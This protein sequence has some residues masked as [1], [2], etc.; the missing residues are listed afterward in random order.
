M[1]KIFIA[2]LCLIA[3]KFAEAQNDKL[4]IGIMPFNYTNGAASYQDANS[5]QEAVTEGFVKTKRFNIVDRSKMDALKKEKE[6]QKTE[7]FIDGSVVKQGANIG[8]NFLI[9]GNVLE[10]KAEAIVGTKGETLGYKAKLI[11][12]LKVID[13]STGQVVSSETIEPKANTGLFGG[14]TAPSTPEGAIS[15]AIKEISGKI[16]EF[17]AKNFPVTFAIAEIQ[18]KDKN[19]GASKV[20][21]SGGAAFG[22]KKGQKL[23]VV[24]ISEMTVNGK[25]LVR[26]KE[27]GELKITKVEDDNFS[28]CDVSSGGTEITKE[29]DAKAKIEVITK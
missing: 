7:D 23:K 29:F 20:L 25:K 24:E 11:I 8:A 27:L 9:S 14:F 13:V 1:R 18:L 15:K 10:A 12:S 6:L 28:T 21:I 17:V 16:D 4:T 5:I 2:I 22:L 26:K 3:A 19:G